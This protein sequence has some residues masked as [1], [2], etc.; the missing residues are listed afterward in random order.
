MPRNHLSGRFA[1]ILM[2]NRVDCPVLYAFARGRP[3]HR[4]IS[5]WMG[6]KDRPEIGRTWLIRG[7]MRSETRV[8]IPSLLLPNFETLEK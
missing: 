2:E 6:G 5:I 4:S 1:T 3:P 7:K 8:Q